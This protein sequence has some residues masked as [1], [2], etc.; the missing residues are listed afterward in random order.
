MSNMLTYQDD[1]K[2]LTV[3]PLDRYFNYLDLN[4]NSTKYSVVWCTDSWNISVS[5]MSFALPC[6]FDGDGNLIM[7]TLWYN[8]SL[9]F[10]HL[11]RPAHSPTPNQPE[12][13]FLQEAID[14]AII[15]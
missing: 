15:S 12:L 1:V 10:T 5:D 3:G 4:P 6:K 14:N 8:Q 11:F 2:K 7:Y 13:V 9:Q